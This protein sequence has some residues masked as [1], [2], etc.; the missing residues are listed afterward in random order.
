MKKCIGDYWRSRFPGS[1]HW[2]SDLVKANASGSVSISV[3]GVSRAF[4]DV[5]IYPKRG[6]WLVLPVIARM[7][8]GMNSSFHN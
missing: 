8:A 5:D 6:D 7:L 2:R 3:P 1:R 4:H